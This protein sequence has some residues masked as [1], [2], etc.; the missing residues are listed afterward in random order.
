MNRNS[1][2]REMYFKF[3]QQYYEPKMQLVTKAM[4]VDYS[5]FAKWKAGKVE[6]SD[7]ILDRIERFLN[8]NL[9]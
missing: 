5:H 3:Y 6:L 9:K 1:K 8:N 2:L 4:G 7:E